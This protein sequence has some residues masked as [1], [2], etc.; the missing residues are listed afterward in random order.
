MTDRGWAGVRNGDLLR[1]MA[2]AGFV[3]LI[4]SDANLGFQHVI[5][6][7]PVF[8]VVIRARSNRITDLR[9]LVPKVLRAIATARPGQVVQV[10]V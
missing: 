1:R 10:D 5:S 7:M 9:P 6:R 8:V 4:T 2:D 3:G